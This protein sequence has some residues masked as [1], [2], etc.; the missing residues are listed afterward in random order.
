MS[1]EILKLDNLSSH[2]GKD[3]VPVIRDISISLMPG[4]VLGIVGESG[5]GKTTLLKTV[6]DPGLHGILI[7]RG[8]ILFYG[9]E[10]G[11]LSSKE[12]RE[13]LGNRIGYIVQDSISSLNPIKKIKHQI[14]ELMREKKGWKKEEALKKGLEL[15]L[16]LGCPENTLEKYPFQLS[17]GQRQRALIAMTLMLEPELLLADEPTTALDVSV[18]AQIL[19]EMKRLSREQGTAMVLVTHNMGLIAGIADEI[20]VMYKG[21]VV[22]YGEAGNIFRQP[23]HPYTGA[24]LKCIPYLSQDRQ[25]E[26]YH[27]HEPD[28]S[29]VSECVF[30]E[31]CALCSGK[32]LDGPV[33]KQQTEKGWYRCHF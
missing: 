14:I 3:P 30:A 21:E 29:I 2:Y 17:G 16:K 15:L 20:A 32:C 10:L 13:L 7:D 12:R 9:T 6:I 27:I 25:K 31:R 8:N 23:G 28:G 1:S 18:Q 4:K 24:L 19:K 11:T 33:P 5:C 26:L 22:E